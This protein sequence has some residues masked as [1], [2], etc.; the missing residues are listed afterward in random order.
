MTNTQ[1]Y[2]SLKNK[3]TRV[4]SNYCDQLAEMSG[5]YIPE[6]RLGFLDLRGFGPRGTREKRT[7]PSD[8]TLDCSNV[9]AVPSPLLSC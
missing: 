2:N 9:E 8:P 6:S 5:C 3:Y 7:N 4:G 1:V